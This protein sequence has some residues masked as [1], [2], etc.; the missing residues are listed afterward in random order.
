MPKASKPTP[1]IITP[2]GGK[3]KP[4]PAAIVKIPSAWRIVAVI[5]NLNE[6]LRG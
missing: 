4:A 6:E 2:A 5:T 1:K 3:S